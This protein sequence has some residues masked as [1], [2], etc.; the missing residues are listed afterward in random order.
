[1]TIAPVTDLAATSSSA[2]FGERYRLVRA[3]IVNV[4]KFTH[5]EFAIDGGRVVLRG[6]NG[7][8]KSRGMDMLFPFLLTGDRRRMGSGS[9]GAVTVDSLM[10]VMLGKDNNR[11][12]YVWAEYVNGDGEY[13]T[14]GAYFK[15]SAKSGKT[16]VSFFITPLRVGIDLPLM[17]EGRHP[18]SRTQLGELVGT[19]NV[20]EQATE[21]ANR[22][23]QELFGVTDNAGRTRLSAAFSVMYNL[24]SPD[25][26]N[27]YRAA[28]VTRVLTSALPSMPDATIRAAGLKLDNLK[29][30]RD[31]L[32]DLEEASRLAS[33]T[34]QVYRGYTA[35][36]VRQKAATLTDAVAA[37]EN[38]AS[39]ELAAREHEA[40]AQAKAQQKEHEAR[41]L[42]GR[43]TLLGGRKSALESSAA[44]SD[45]LA[46]VDR[47]KTADALKLAAAAELSGWWTLYGNVVAATSRAAKAG[48]AVTEVGNRLGEAM[49]ASV[50]HG[51][52]AGLPHSLPAVSVLVETSPERTISARHTVEDEV[53]DTPIPGI[54][55][56]RSTPAD[57]DAV[58]VKLGHLR[59]AA[60]TKQNT[61]VGRLETIQ[62]IVADETGVAA[63]EKEA[64]RASKTAYALKGAAVTAAENSAA[65]RA[66][67]VDAWVKWARSSDTEEL[68][69]VVNWDDT[70]LADLIT[71]RALPPRAELDGAANRVAAD[72]F[73]KIAVAIQ[74]IGERRTAASTEADELAA[75]CTALESHVIRAPEQPR[76][77]TAE[78]GT[79]FWKT[80]DFVSEVPTH[81]QAAVEAAL[82]SSGILIGAVTRNG[83]VPAGGELIVSAVGPVSSHPIIEVLTPEPGIPE[84]AAI[85]SR[86]GFN[87][88]DHP[89]NIND[90]GSW[91]VGAI[92]GRPDRLDDARHIGAAAQ[93][94]SRQARL[95]E[96]AARVDELDGILA[97]LEVE[98]AAALA[99]RGATRA[100][101][102]AAPSSTRLVQAD[103]A[104]RAAREAAEVAWRESV[105]AVE[106]ALTE[107]SVWDERNTVHRRVCEH[108][109]LPAREPELRVAVGRLRA[110]VEACETAIA[111]A[112]SVRQQI[113]ALD[114]AV[115]EIGTANM[116]AED[117]KLTA[118]QSVDRWRSEA[119]AVRELEATIGA[120]AEQMITELASVQNELAAAVELK[121]KADQQALETASKHGAAVTKVDAATDKAK[122]EAEKADLAA[123]HVTTILRLPGIAEAASAGSA[124][125]PDDD[126]APALDDWV[127]VHVT[128]KKIV[129]IDAVH[130]AVDTLREHV[131]QMFDVYR[132]T[133]GDVLLVEV[134]DGDTIQPLPAAAADLAA[135]A[136]TG[137]NALVEAEYEMFSNF[138]IDGVADDM[139]KTIRLASE[140]IHDTSARVSSH[141]TSNGIGVR[142][143]FA[144]KDDVP[145]SA[146]RIREL[147][148]I[149]DAA[150]T[151]DQNTALSNLLRETVEEAYN[152]NRAEG[153]GKALADSLDY[154]NWYTVQPIVLGP[155][156]GQERTL[157]S[158]KLSEGE[159][160][161]VTYLALISALDSHLSALPAIAPRLMLL[162]D[163]YAMVDDHGRRILTSILVER[164]IDFMM[165]GF[166]LW[167]HYANVDSLD[168]YEIASTGDDSPTTAI[169][170]HWD[171]QRHRPRIA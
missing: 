97:K 10:K 56:T 36:L 19:Q 125:A 94:R 131:T 103:T 34:L 15:Y 48:I 161:Y 69:G 30:T 18:L 118:E 101:V 51:T 55:S 156:P 150:R 21:Y 50:E 59:E 20:I 31:Q 142:L 141:R 74:R 77:V 88:P 127:R 157:K 79:P 148:A 52:A 99:R 22:V 90:D 152:L 170:F 58:T 7:S 135:R 5:V 49:R 82:H 119:A 76:W 96:I 42:A 158:A 140:T 2:G 155:T 47:Q 164:D 67:L 153:Y 165:T 3:G 14:I 129:S 128:K 112:G 13:R 23:A 95:T 60:G 133:I 24:R 43:I 6:P 73:D 72:A 38:A 87:D 44:Y 154:R 130:Q 151:S 105:S 62:R 8:G 17:D 12:G 171:G 28:D 64:D 41:E 89:V 16:A 132:H 53:T 32:N 9:S 146:A 116:I 123:A 134:N 92:A 137:R 100:H 102:N 167:L 117:A 39:A 110:T 81:I 122:E 61:A 147:V 115:D 68:L 108:A 121:A 98:N 113:L 120:T 139:R 145:E 168:E 149:A 111:L 54:P 27:K 80:V 75:E 63:T 138:I 144:P 70:P 91:R 25:F 1:M 46:F 33:E 114:I 78:L 65:A 40:D 162:D 11:V 57:L 160:R 29:D 107:R 93:E 109:G 83:V 37:A 84:I 169:R 143:R 104:E 35:S 26:G 163:A 159:L 85:L 126:T 136:E 86:I 4:H 106:T 124:T 71:E 166:D 66:D 45:A